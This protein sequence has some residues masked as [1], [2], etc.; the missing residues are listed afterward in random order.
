MPDPLDT[1]G[2]MTEPVEELPTLAL[3]RLM[4]LLGLL[5][6]KEFALALEAEREWLRKGLRER[7]LI[8]LLLLFVLAVVAGLEELVVVVAVAVAS[9]AAV[10]FGAPGTVDIGGGP[11]GAGRGA[12]KAVEL[13]TLV[14]I[15]RILSESSARVAVAKRFIW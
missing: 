4:T 7:R 5:S 12:V 13:E 8:G 11:D 14:D 6:G 10:T 2:V 3:P 1:L 15:P 9:V